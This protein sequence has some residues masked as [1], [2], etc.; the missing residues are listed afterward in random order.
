VAVVAAAVAGL[1]LSSE[2]E[3]EYR[4]AM[5]GGLEDRWKSKQNIFQMKIS[6]TNIITWTKCQ[7]IG[8]V[9]YSTTTTPTD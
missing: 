2:F 9:R 4:L 5:R 1:A 6:K 3:S 8:V 7:L